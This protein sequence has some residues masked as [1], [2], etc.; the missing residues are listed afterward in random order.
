MSIIRRSSG[1]GVRSSGGFNVLNDYGDML[2][3][4]RIVRYIAIEGCP[5]SEVP[6]YII[7]MRSSIILSDVATLH[8]IVVVAH[9]NRNCY[10]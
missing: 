2:Q 10:M 6:L 3:A 1:R 4:F 5:L 9:Y 8:G 7:C